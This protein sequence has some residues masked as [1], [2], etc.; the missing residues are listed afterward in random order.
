MAGAWAGVM[1]D[2]EDDNLKVAIVLAEVEGVEVGGALA[3]VGVGM[4]DGSRTL[5]LCPNHSCHFHRNS[6]A[7]ARGWMRKKEVRVYGPVASW[8][9]G[10]GTV[11]ASA[12]V[13]DD[14]GV[15]ALEVAVV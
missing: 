6:A 1:D 10:D 11:E 4:E 15:D 14:V 3:V 9:S 5:K 2:V 8:A 13:V 7:T 12:G